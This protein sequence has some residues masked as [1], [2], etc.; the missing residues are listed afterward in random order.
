[1]VRVRVRVRYRGRVRGVSK[2]FMVRIYG[3]VTGLG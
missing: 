1:M 3:R 2:V